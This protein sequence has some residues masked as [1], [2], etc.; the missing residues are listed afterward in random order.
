MHAGRRYTLKEFVY[1]TRRDI[2]ILSIF[3]LIP[4]VLY[5]CVGLKWLAL[6]WVPI[7]LIG[8]AAAF[9]VGFR[10]TQTYN[11]VWEARQIYG[12]IVNTSRSF[13]M[14]VKDYIAGDNEAHVKA[15]HRQMIHRH[16]AWLTA[17]RF[18]LR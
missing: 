12:S 1:W 18:Q 3:A 13:G 15:I 10:N 6:P 9:I 7:A 11:R 8:T 14:L 5:E 2:Y 17:L 4:T 16:L